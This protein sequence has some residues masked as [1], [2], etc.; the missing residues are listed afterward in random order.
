M[1]F[2]VDSLKT[3]RTGQMVH[4]RVDEAGP[5]SMQGTLV[6]EVH[7]APQPL[8][9]LLNAQSRRVTLPL[10]PVA[11]TAPPRSAAVPPAAGN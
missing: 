11:S 4:V 7:E 10:T 5:W 8:R 3:D 2:P 1:F 6:R 9:A